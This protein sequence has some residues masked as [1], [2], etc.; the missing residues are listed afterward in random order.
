MRTSGSSEFVYFFDQ[1]LPS[2][3]FGMVSISS[4]SFFEILI[5]FV[6]VIVFCILHSFVGH[7]LLPADD[8]GFKVTSTRTHLM[9]TTASVECFLA[10]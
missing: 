5:R 9:P 3:P 1:Q 4:S 2:S 8:P 10:C 6:A 7:G